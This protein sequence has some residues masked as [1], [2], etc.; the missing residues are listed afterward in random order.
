VSPINEKYKSE[1]ITIKDN[2]NK[3]ENNEVIE[4]KE[5]NGLG[6]LSGIFDE[7][8]SAEPYKIS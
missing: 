3:I 4:V 5:F 7:L 6:E 2:I 8:I 1:I